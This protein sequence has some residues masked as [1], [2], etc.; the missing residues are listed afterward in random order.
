MAKPRNYVVKLVTP[1]LA[2]L[3]LAGAGQVAAEVIKIPVAQ[4]ADA[5]QD[6]ERPA[7]GQSRASVESRFGE[8]LE[9]RG[10]VGDPPITTW[11]YANFKVYFEY[12]HVVHSAFIH[13]PIE[14]ARNQVQ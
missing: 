3:A 4:Q 11:V 2:T 6:L 10:P 9:R 14:T 5:L 12:D 8:P 7:K 1:L 13:V